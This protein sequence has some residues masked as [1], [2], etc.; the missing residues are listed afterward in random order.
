MSDPIP[1]WSRAAVNFRAMGRCEWCGKR[2][3]RLE[4]HHRLY[5]SRKSNRHG[6][7]NLVGLCGWGN[8]T[9][10]HGKAHTDRAA[11]E[12]AGMSIPSHVE[13]LTVPIFSNVFQLTMWIAADGFTQFHKP[14]IVLRLEEQQ[15]A[16]T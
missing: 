12:A 9:G 2:A 14:D 7:E 6:P 3:E 16:E 5:R 8:T 10:C 4:M 1:A 13:P 15:R 11:A